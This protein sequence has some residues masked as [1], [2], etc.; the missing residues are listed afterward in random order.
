MTD[1]RSEKRLDKRMFDYSAGGYCGVVMP[2]H[3]MKRL[4][5]LNHKY[6]SEVR[7]ILHA[8]KDE[9]YVSDWALANDMDGDEIKMQVVIRYSIPNGDDLS[10]SVERRIELFQ[11]AQPNYIEEFFLCDSRDEAREIAKEILRD[12]LEGESE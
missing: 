3:V 1:I 11:A 8:H 6:S 12:T 2:E 9:L 10:E 4:A 7:K 5:K